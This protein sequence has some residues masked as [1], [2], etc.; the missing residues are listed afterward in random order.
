VNTNERLDGVGTSAYLGELLSLCK[1]RELPAC[2]R[3]G[4]AT[5]TLLRW[6]RGSTPKDGAL[7]LLRRS[8]MEIADEAGTLPDHLLDEL[9]HLRETVEL[10][11]AKS[12]ASIESRVD[13][14][15]RSVAE[16]QSAA[17]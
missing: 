3:A 4:I 2:K 1:V 6:R 5:S 17:L 12:K 11:E 14:L 9:A 15:E 10:P 7:D 16:L 8:V 13:A